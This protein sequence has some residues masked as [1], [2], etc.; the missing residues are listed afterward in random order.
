MSFV[1]LSAFE[2][3]DADREFDFRLTVKRTCYDSFY[4]FGILSSRGLSRL[5]FEPV[6]LLYGGNG[7]GKTTAIN[8]IGD[9]LGLTRGALYNRSN[10]FSDYTQLCHFE[11]RKPIPGKSRVITSD[12]VFDYMIDMRAINE[13]LDQQREDLFEEYRDLKDPNKEPFRLQSI[14]DYEQLKKVVTARRLTQS[15]FV[16]AGMKN[17]IREHSNGENAYSFFTEMIREN[18]LYLL[19]EPENSLSPDNQQQLTSFLEESA[20]FYSCQFVIAT[21]SP[22]LLAMHGARIYD[23]DSNPACIRKWTDLANV[24]AY[25]DFFKKHYLEFEERNS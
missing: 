1:Y 2:F 12:D 7:S 14:D 10:F 15:R 5:E 19:D 8:I 13:G 25:Y 23:L 21:H 18:G 9:T 4:P 24:R 22:F 16:R 11:L 17:N 3:P 20:R 6:T